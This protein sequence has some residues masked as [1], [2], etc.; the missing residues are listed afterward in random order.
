MNRKS[1][2]ACF[3]ISQQLCLS[4][5]PLFVQGQVTSSARYLWMNKFSMHQYMQACV[6]VCVC[7]CAHSCCAR[8]AVHSYILFCHSN[9]SLG[10][11]GVN[12][13]GKRGWSPWL[14]WI[15]S[16]MPAMGYNFT[17]CQVTSKQGSTW[18]F[19]HKKEEPRSEE[20][21]STRDHWIHV[22]LYKPVVYL[23]VKFNIEGI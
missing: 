8:R 17:F 19:V 9:L 13:K 22:L 2:K 15:K 21:A 16:I 14:L 18:S 20:T 10:G 1:S 5:F 23:Y 7:L 11:R 6:P 4:G 3:V 12:S